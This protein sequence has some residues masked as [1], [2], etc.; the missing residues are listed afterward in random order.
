[1]ADSLQAG[2][3]WF[4]DTKSRPFTEKVGR[5]ADYY[6]R[7]YGQKPNTCVVWAE[8]EVEDVDG[9]EVMGSRSVQ[10]D[11]FWIGVREG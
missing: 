7:K 9:I 4:D 10:P 5:A 3:L 8:T 2:M 6:Q 1:M 11:H